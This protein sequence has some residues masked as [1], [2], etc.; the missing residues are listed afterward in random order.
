MEAEEAK[1]V[2]TPLQQGIIIQ[3]NW[4]QRQLSNLLQLVEGG[5]VGQFLFIIIIYWIFIYHHDLL[6]PQR[7]QSR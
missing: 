5:L 6:S 7:A 1:T 3:A 2:S 4:K